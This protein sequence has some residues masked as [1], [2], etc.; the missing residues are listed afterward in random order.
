V[1]WSPSI[2]WNTPAGKTLRKLFAALPKDRQHSLTLFGSSPIQLGIDPTFTSNDVDIF[3]G[4]WGESS[5]ELDDLVQRI[6]LG[7]DQNPDVYV[8]VCVE[9]NFRSSPLWKDRAFRVQIENINLTLPHPID[10]LIAKLHRLEEKDLRAFRLVIARTGHPT[11]DELRRELQIAVD[12]Y[13]P[14]FDEELV[15]DIT[16]YTRVLWQE[17]WGK[18]IDVRQE[19][20]APAVL[21]RN[22]GYA[23][24]IAREDYRSRLR[25]LGEK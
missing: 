6:G 9:G 4:D 19:I 2:D 21:R 7:K 11:E 18:E 10:I 22:E 5:Q 13:R 25:D 24:D 15:G 23:D 17:L 14:G 8:Q 1:S 20:I 16:I 12:L 3:A